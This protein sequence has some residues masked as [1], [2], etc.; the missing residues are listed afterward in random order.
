M[1]KLWIFLFVIFFCGCFQ[2]DPQK[3]EIPQTQTAAKTSDERIAELIK[4]KQAVVPFFKPMGVPLKTDWLATNVEAGQTFEEYVKSKP[5]LPT[6]ARKKIYIQPI[7]KFSAAQRKVLLL[8][9]A[10]MRVFYN[11]PVELKSEKNL[12]NVPSEMTRKNLYTRQTQIKTS[13]FLDNLLPKMLPEDAAALISFTNSDL[14]P[15]AGWSY[16]FGEAN[17]QGRVGVWSLYRLGNPD[18][19]PADYKLFLTRTLKI[20][21]HETGHIFSMRH[22]TKYECL[23]S[24]T[25]NLQETDRRPVDDCPECMAKIAWAMNY[26]PAERYANLAKFW[27]EQ[28]FTELSREFEAKEKAVRQVSVEKR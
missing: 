12:E 18:K 28:G 19:S 10:Y 22:C 1:K 15:E 4:I 5:V 3:P 13:Y 7:G 17:L 23:M 14:F 8:T 9:A 6:A 2:S 27:Q 26:A 16:V 25:N 21:M 24:G 11:L 20:A